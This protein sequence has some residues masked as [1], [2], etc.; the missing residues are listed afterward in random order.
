VLD[1]TDPSAAPLCDACADAALLVFTLSAVQPAHMATVLRLAY[2]SLRPG[3][4]LLFR[5]YAEFDLPMVR[6]EATGKQKLGDRLYQRQ[7]GTLAYFFSVEDIGQRA[8]DAGF[9]INELKYAC[10]HNRSHSKAGLQL[11]KRAFVHGV[12]SR[13]SD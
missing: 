1:A 6:F 2:E 12:F 10:V 13:P 8:D 3:G 11:L 5:D 9:V 7:D 4:V